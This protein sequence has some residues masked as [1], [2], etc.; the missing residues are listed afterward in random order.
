MENRYLTQL[1]WVPIQPRPKHRWHQ[2]LY[3]IV[4]SG[5]NPFLNSAC[6]QC[7]TP[8]DIEQTTHTCNLMEANGFSNGQCPAVKRNLMCPCP[9]NAGP[10]ASVRHKATLQNALPQ[11][12]FH[13]DRKGAAAKAASWPWSRLRIQSVTGLFEIRLCFP[14]NS[15]R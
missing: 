2:E 3:R 1:A 4:H 7:L 11:S 14:A 5:N 13:A 12:C 15:L 10:G 8:V 9:R 6:A